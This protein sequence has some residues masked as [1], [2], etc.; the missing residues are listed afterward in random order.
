MIWPFTFFI[1]MSKNS[2]SFELCF[3]VNFIFGCRFYSRLCNSLMSSRG[4]FQNMKQTSKY[5]FNDLVNSSFKSLP[6]FLPIISYRF[7]PKYARVRI[8]YVGAIL[9]PMAVPWFWI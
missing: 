1:R 6:Y 3:I 5:L 2:I 7:S 9:F 4:H 8:A